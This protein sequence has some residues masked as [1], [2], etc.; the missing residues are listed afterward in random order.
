MDERERGELVARVTAGDADAL[1][2]LIVEYHRVLHRV[3]SGALPTDARARVDAEDV[4]QEA[5]VSAFKALGIP[6]RERQGGHDPSPER[7]RGDEPIRDRAREND[8][9][10]DRARGGDPS[11]DREGAVRTPRFDTPA[12]FYKWLEA[13]AL[14]VL[15]NMQRDLHRRRRDVARE[16]HAAARA[17]STY[18]DMLDRLTQTGSTPS[19]HVARDEAVAALLSSLARLTAEQREVIRLRFLEQ[20]SVPEVAAQLGKT[21]PAIHA[22]C[23]RALKQLRTHLGSVSRYL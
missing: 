2:R 9:I 13:I 17:D 8:P 11:R 7:E 23:Y 12:G 16:V 18:T 15:K 1:Q 20:R 19:R 22:L 4:L 3:I 10:R 6:N 14:N 21:E 5:Y